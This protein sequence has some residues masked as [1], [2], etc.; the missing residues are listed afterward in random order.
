[1]HGSVPHGHRKP[2]VQVAGRT[3]LADGLQPFSELGIGHWPIR[4]LPND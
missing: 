2:I 3:L 1:M 4:R